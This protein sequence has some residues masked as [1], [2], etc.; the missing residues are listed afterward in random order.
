MVLTNQGDTI[1]DMGR[2][3]QEVVSEIKI[4]DDRAVK[5]ITKESRKKRRA[6]VQLS[7]DG[8]SSDD[9]DSG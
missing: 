3:C 5:N 2:M 8:S 4:L 1:A 7:A 6:S 9:K